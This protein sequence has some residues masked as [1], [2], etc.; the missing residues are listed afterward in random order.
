MPF[1]GKLNLCGILT[2]STFRHSHGSLNRKV[3][4]PQKSIKTFSCNPNRTEPN[5]PS[6][7]TMR[8]VWS[9]CGSCFGHK[10]RDRSPC[11]CMCGVTKIDIQFVWFLRNSPAAAEE[12]SHQLTKSRNFDLIYSV[13]SSRTAAT[14]PFRLRTTTIP[15]SRRSTLWIPDAADW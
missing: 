6:E 14:V 10:A 13:I 2:A 5:S 3:P 8:R 1:H 12:E 11:V 7:F 15:L 4:R 9:I